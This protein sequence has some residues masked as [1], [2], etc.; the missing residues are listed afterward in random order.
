MN[1]DTQHINWTRVVAH[2]EL[3][4]VCQTFF[5][6][7]YPMMLYKNEIYFYLQ[8]STMEFHKK[9]VQYERNSCNLTSYEQCLKL[10]I[11]ELTLR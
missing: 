8:Y 3:Y 10:C 7:L 9:D 6:L 1:L 11:T 4:L 2:Y 5:I